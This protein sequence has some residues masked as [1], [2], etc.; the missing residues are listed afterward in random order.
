M[1]ALHRSFL[2][3]SLLFAFAL[4]LS[5]QTTGT[6]LGRVLDE[7]GGALPGATVEVRSPALQG[8]RSA[9]TDGTGAYRFSLLPPGE[10]TVTVTLQGFATESREVAVSLDKDTTLNP[11]LRAA[12]S[13]EITVTSE[14]P[15]IDATS[16]TLGTNLD[17]RAIETLPTGR[18]YASVV[19]ITPGVAS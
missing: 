1:N 5:A 14:I 2:L 19:Q 8:T 7:D 17:T 13:E 4:T 10:Y 11:V 18:N 15:V 6:L 12:V 3:F 16:T 9:V